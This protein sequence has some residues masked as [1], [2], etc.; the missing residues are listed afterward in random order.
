MK[1]VALTRLIGHVGWLVVALALGHYFLVLYGR[2]LL[3]FFPT[4]AFL[5]LGF[6]GAVIALVP[7]WS[8]VQLGD[9][10]ALDRERLINAALWVVGYFVGFGL[11]V[12]RFGTPVV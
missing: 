8:R 6:G 5:A 1:H 7:P 10:R 2:Y 4:I 12:A 11:L 9:N 3:N